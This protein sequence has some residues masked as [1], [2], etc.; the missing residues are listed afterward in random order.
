[1]RFNAC[2]IRLF[3]TADTWVVNR[4]A[5]VPKKNA[6]VQPFEEKEQNEVHLTAACSIRR[7]RGRTSQKRAEAVASMATKR[8]SVLA[9]TTVVVCNLDVLGGDRRGI[10]VSRQ[11]AEPTWKDFLICRTDE[12][13]QKLCSM[14]L[15]SRVSPQFTP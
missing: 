5:D 13:Q 9:V 10:S 11:G 7:K 15:L 14:F 3:F 4:P 6:L 1:M 8:S 2:L 12:V